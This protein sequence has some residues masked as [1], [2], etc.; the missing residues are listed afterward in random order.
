MDFALFMERYG[1]K[2]LLGVFAIILIGFFAVLGFWIYAMFKVFGSIAAIA[3][4]GYFIYAFVVKRRV[5]DAQAEAHGKY[6]YDP[7]YGKKR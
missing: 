2:I 6:F 5:L 7:N 1:Y 4:V 3:I